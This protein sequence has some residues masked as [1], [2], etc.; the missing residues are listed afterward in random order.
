[1]VSLTKLSLLL[2]S[3]SPAFTLSIQNPFKLSNLPGADTK[4]IP[5]ESPLQ[6]C[7]IQ[8]SQLLHLSQVILYPNPPVRVAN[9]TISAIGTLTKDIEDGSY[10]D[11]DVTYG[12]I[13]LLHQTYDICE[14]LPQIDMECPVTKGY[15][16][17]TKIVEIP[18]EVPPGKYSVTARA[19]TKDDE[20]ITCLTGAVEFPSYG[21]LNDIL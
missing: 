12:Y 16:Q 4:P 7:D 10:V 19:Y 17:L 5:G 14:E 20:L 11:V 2:L 6:Q 18:N 8:S 21:L 1:M 15:Y 3:T 9:L 13:K